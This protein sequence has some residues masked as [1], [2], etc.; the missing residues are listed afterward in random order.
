M[1]IETSTLGKAMVTNALKTWG[2]D[3]S[4]LYE[5]HDIVKLINEDKK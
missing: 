5:H 4:D 1:S 3:G 2:Q